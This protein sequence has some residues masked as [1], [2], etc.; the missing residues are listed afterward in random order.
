MTNDDAFTIIDPGGPSRHFTAERDPADNGIWHVYSPGGPASDVLAAFSPRA[1]R[2]CSGRRTLGGWRRKVMLP[3]AALDALM[4]G[5][6]TPEGVAATL[7]PETATA[8]GLLAARRLR[9]ALTAAP[10]A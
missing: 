9:A 2:R 8:C 4:G 1:P 3:E 7:T 6:A 5:I 10:P